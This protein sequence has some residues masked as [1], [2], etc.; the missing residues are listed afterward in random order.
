MEKMKFLLGILIEPPATSPDE[1]LESFYQSTVKS[2]LTVSYKFPDV[3][4]TVYI[5]G[6]FMEWLKDKHSEFLTVITEMIKRKQV[7]ILSGG[8][9]NPLLPLIPAS[10]RL[11]QIEE[12][13]T[14]V[15]KTLGRRPRGLWMTKTIWDSSVISHLNGSGIEYTF[16]DE[17]DF[18]R[19]GLTEEAQAFPRVTEN[20][21]KMLTVF[22]VNGR[23]SN[24]VIQGDV[25]PFNLAMEKRLSYSD[26]FF[27][28]F[29]SLNA[30]GSS[31]FFLREEG[32][33]GF[34][35]MLRSRYPE[36]DCVTPATF[37]K[38]NNQPLQRSYFASTSYEEMTSRFGQPV[39]PD[40]HQQSWKH[41]LTDFEA[42]NRLYSKMVYTHILVTSLRGDK[43]K[44]KSAAEELWKAQD[45]QAYL[46]ISRGTG[47]LARKRAFVSLLHAESLLRDR[48]HFQPALTAQDFDLDGI[49]E[50]LYQGK[51]FNF[52]VDSLGGQV[53]EWDYLDKPWNYVDASDHGNQLKVRPQMFVDRFYHKM[54]PSH[55]AGDFFAREYK[56]ADFNREQKKMQFTA[57]SQIRGETGKQPLRL[58]KTFSF[59]EREL[60]LEYGLELLSG[61][62]WEGVFTPES[63]LSFPG[64]GS[65]VFQCMGM[66]NESSGAVVRDLDRDLEMVWDWSPTAPFDQSVWKPTV[67]REETY[68][69]HRITPRWTVQLEPGQHWSGFIRMKMNLPGV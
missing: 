29:L 52:Y 43:Y 5:S 54:D 61:P 22:P 20:Q 14:L 46:P 6:P 40:S 65:A 7:E 56:M 27:S 38:K 48:A 57:V 17:E 49:K 50:F 15:R 23:I 67:Y 63:Y 4:L 36:T 45:I 47:D 18:R 32:Y 16:L 21:G 41:F 68:Q 39:K 12:L 9:Y 31:S 59:Q 62:P 34:L 51:V 60:F 11:G 42:S 28:L 33:K 3:P 26:S 69:A 8:F 2:F 44:K 19:I 10:D 58:T 1:V 24:Q 25:Q 55:D 35:E 30:E 66:E 64:E 53:F 13:T 37:F